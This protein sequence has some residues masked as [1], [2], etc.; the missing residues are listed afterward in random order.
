MNTGK[1]LSDYKI[2]KIIEAFLRCKGLAEQLG[3]NQKPLLP[4]FV[5]C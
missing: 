4:D 3:W 2:K 5:T 1:H